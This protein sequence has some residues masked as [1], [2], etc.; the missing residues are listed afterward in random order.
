MCIKQNKIF[1]ILFISGF[2]ASINNIIELFNN[3]LSSFS[4]NEDI[5][6]LIICICDKDKNDYNITI[7]KF[8]NVSCF[9]VPFESEGKEKLI[10]KYNI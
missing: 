5:L 8:I 9:I 4:Q 3:L 2:V 1:G 6:K 7:S 10:N